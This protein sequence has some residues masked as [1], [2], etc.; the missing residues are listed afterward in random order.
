[1]ACSCSRNAETAAAGGQL[2]IDILNKVPWDV[3]RHLLNG[4]VDGWR[5]LGHRLKEMGPL[6]NLLTVRHRFVPLVLESTTADFA[7]PQRAL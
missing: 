3:L 5:T 6:L 4:G 2:V 1:M 7:V